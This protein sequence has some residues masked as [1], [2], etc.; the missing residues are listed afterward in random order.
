M[1][2][3]ALSV[4]M[5]ALRAFQVLITW[6][7]RSHLISLI[8]TLICTT[9]RKYG[10]LSLKKSQVSNGYNVQDTDDIDDDWEVKDYID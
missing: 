4:Y 3:C 10:E 6:G 2:L 5:Y 7:L 1:D 8:C 9:Y